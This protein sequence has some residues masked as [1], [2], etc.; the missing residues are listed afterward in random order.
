MSSLIDNALY[1]IHINRNEGSPKGAISLC[2][3]ALR[4]C[5]IEHAKQIVLD[6]YG[7]DV[8]QINSKLHAEGSATRRTT[9][10]RT[11]AFADV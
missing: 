8:K 10:N 4:E 5:D 11:K 9:T 1:Y 7:E 6:A 2:S 3:N